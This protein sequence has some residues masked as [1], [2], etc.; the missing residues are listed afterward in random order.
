[1]GKQTVAL[2]YRRRAT[3]GSLEPLLTDAA[4]CLNVSFFCKDENLRKNK[5]F[6]LSTKRVCA[7]NKKSLCYQQKETV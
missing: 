4:V 5:S 3:N 1:M 2:K 6:V 7:I